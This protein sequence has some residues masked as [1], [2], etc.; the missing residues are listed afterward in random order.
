MKVH[1]RRIYLQRRMGNITMM[2]QEYQ[3]DLL[4]L[5]PI[6]SKSDFHPFRTV[7]KEERVPSLINMVTSSL[8]HSIR[9]INCM[10]RVRSSI[11]W[12]PYK[13]VDLSMESSS[14]EPMWIYLEIALR[15]VLTPHLSSLSRVIMYSLVVMVINI[16]VPSQ[17]T[18]WKVLVEWPMPTR[19]CMM[20]NGR[21]AR[22]LAWASS[23]MERKRV[24]TANGR[25]IKGMDK[26][27]LSPRTASIMVNGRMTRRRVREWWPIRMETSMRVNG[28]MTRRRA[29]ERWPLRMETSMR[30]NGRMTRR[31]VREWWPI[32]METSMRVNGRMTR[33]RARERLLI[34]VAI[35]W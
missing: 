9:T 31:K 8:E 34:L 7:N 6:N 33:E 14:R 15:W 22:E 2:L 23:F 32:R 3:M 11:I 21:M 1:G 12:Q 26:A 18:W 30:V 5:C 20:V 27:C 17:R 10:V 16:M 25:K 24:T 13:R 28:R 4:H 29:R 35:N 19:L